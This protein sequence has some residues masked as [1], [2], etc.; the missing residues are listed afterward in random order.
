M[1]ELTG[2]SLMKS[3]G[4]PS[5]RREVEREFWRV[6][7]TGVTGERA[8]LAVGVSQA[9][10]ARWF[11]Q[12]GGMP[13]MDLAALSGRCLSFAER[14]EI[15]IL[16]AQGAGVRV[17]ARRLGR[18]PSTISRELRRTC[19]RFNVP[20]EIK[21]DSHRDLWKAMRDQLMAQYTTDPATD[22]YG[23]YLV[24]W[25]A[26]PN[27]PASR[28]PDGSRPSTPE[29]LRRRLEQELTADQARKIAVIVMDVT[30][31][32]RRAGG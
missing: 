5:L 14:E 25:F 23:I 12:G 1:K 2:R 10:G 6:I 8:A 9:A 20:I 24:L 30:K 11:R 15:A 19:R 32:S 17:I 4:A 21:K 31:P 13:P 3:P 18:S 26:D 28:H 29:E 7:A 22:G 27:K 16:R